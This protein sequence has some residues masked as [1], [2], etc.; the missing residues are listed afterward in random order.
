MARRRYEQLE[1][2]LASEAARA[3]FRSSYFDVRGLRTPCDTADPA[4]VPLPATAAACRSCRCSTSECAP[5]AVPAFA[6][7]AAAVPAPTSLAALLASHVLRDGEA[8]LLVLRPSLWFIVLSSLRW[9][10]AGAALVAIAAACGSHYHGG[11]FAGRFRGCAEAGVAVIAGRLMWGALQWM[12]RLYV[13]T[14]LRLLTLSGVLR[15]D[16]FDCALRKVA[17]TRLLRSGTDRLL[18]IGSIEI[19]P[20]DPN[21]PFALWQQVARPAEVHEQ[22]V[23]TLN[24]AKQGHV[25]C[26]GGDALNRRLPH[27]GTRRNASNSACPP[28]VFSWAILRDRTAGPARRR[29]SPVWV[30]HRI[31]VRRAGL[32]ARGG[33]DAHLGA[34]ALGRSHRQQAP[35]DLGM[36]LAHRPRPGGVGVPPA[37]I[38]G[39]RGRA[40]VAV[41]GGPPTVR[42]GGGPARAGAGDVLLPADFLQFRGARLRRCRAAG[43]G[44]VRAGTGPGSARGPNAGRLHGGA[45]QPLPGWPA[46][47]PT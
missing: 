30:E 23:A 12:G 16:V 28:R 44:G 42:P 3:L 22:I 8:V 34:G 19:I 14:D 6:A 4:L 18:G 21:S 2:T 46:S 11:L 33:G 26:P 35:P 38:S 5:P 37:G 27:E 10:A 7:D 41:R 17:R 45:V 25:G 36:A 31:V 15:V 1:T 43:G 9:V 39:R 29:P 40:A 20:Q 47:C 32:V 13:L 24:R